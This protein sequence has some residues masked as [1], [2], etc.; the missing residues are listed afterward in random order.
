MNLAKVNISMLLIQL[1]FI[2]TRIINAQNVLSQPN[3]LIPIEANSSNSI[4]KCEDKGFILIQP[5]NSLSDVVIKQYDSSFNLLNTLNLNLPKKSYILDYY[6][7]DKYCYLIIKL[8]AKE[9]KLYQYEWA[10]LNFKEWDFELPQAHT[11]TEFKATNDCAVILSR[12]G[13]L[14]PSALSINLS[15]GEY[16]SQLIESE[17]INSKHFDFVSLNIEPKNKQI[18]IFASA[19]HG[20]KSES[21]LIFYGTGGYISNELIL[22]SPDDKILRT[23]KIFAFSENEYLFSGYYIDSGFT[24]YGIFTC[25]LSDFASED[26]RFYNFETLSSFKNTFSPK[27]YE[28]YLKDIKNIKEGELNYAFNRSGELQDIIEINGNYLITIEIWES[29]L[30]HDNSISFYQMS[31]LYTLIDTNGTMLWDAATTFNPKV[32]T[33]FHKPIQSINII[34]NQIFTNYIYQD[35]LYNFQIQL[36]SDIIIK[37]ANYLFETEPQSF[38]YEA[39]MK[40]APWNNGKSIIYGIKSKKDMSQDIGKRLSQEIIFKIF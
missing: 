19:I 9:F 6:F 29:H 25:K 21:I 40:V 20:K 33:T 34:H 12:Y 18:Y 16:Y 27:D 36:F 15:T 23:G 4:L 38:Q 7:F 26:F 14:N 3:L 2:T 5:Q 10:N 13:L 8:N 37:S 11:F 31:S 39:K 28:V 35:T 30:N 22:G 1:V 17:S 32:N 24:D